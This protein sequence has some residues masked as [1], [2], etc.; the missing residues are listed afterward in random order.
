MECCD[1]PAAV[2]AM[3]SPNPIFDVL[4]RLV[5]PSTKDQVVRAVHFLRIILD[6]AQSGGHLSVDQRC[7]EEPQSYHRDQCVEGDASKA[8]ASKVRMPL[9][10]VSST[11]LKFICSAHNESIGRVTPAARTDRSRVQGDGY[12][13]VRQVS[14]VQLLRMPWGLPGS[15]PTER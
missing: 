11:T 10:F 6:S 12:V 2:V 8:D 7:L 14:I 4:P 5:R 9:Q 3:R 1:K 15:S 13:L